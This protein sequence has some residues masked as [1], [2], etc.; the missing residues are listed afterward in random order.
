MQTSS[1]RTAEQEITRLAATDLAALWAQ[2]SNFAEADVA[3]NDVLPQLIRTYGDTVA[4]IAAEWYDDARESAGVGGY[5]RSMPAEI[6]DTGAQSLADWASHHGT[7]MDAIYALAKGGAQ[8][9]ILNFSRQTIMQ[10]AHRDP[11]S[12]GWQRTGTGECDFCEML[13]SRGAVYTKA[14][15]DFASHDDC[16]CS[17]V[18]AF[19]G[20]PV[21]VKPYRPSVRH[22]EA[23][24]TRAKSWIDEHLHN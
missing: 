7:S 5:Y 20:R 1:L 3:L 14:T 11:R 8:R 24:Q 10:S 16:R 13:I 15:A 9:R 4:G 22:S 18:P 19:K 21:P 17:A 6:S 23:D 12:A 2:V